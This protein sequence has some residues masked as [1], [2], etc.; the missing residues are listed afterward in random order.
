[1]YEYMRE[2]VAAASKHEADAASYDELL[3]QRA[4]E[5]WQLVAKAFRAN[6]MST[7]GH[8]VLTFKREV[9]EEA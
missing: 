5:G 8:A 2:F 4:S 3:A 9:E 6:A 1:M 7:S